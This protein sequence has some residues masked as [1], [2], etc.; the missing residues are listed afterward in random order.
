MKKN[1]G[2]EILSYNIEAHILELK[3]ENELLRI[4]RKNDENFFD[5]EYQKLSDAYLELCDL[6]CKG[7]SSVGFPPCQFYDFK[8]EKCKLKKDLDL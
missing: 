6:E 2:I 3:K 4:G 8:N 7:D 5:E 1:K